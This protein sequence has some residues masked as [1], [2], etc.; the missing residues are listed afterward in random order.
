MVSMKDISQ[1]C[2]VSV[3]TVSKALNNH[4]DISEA[5]KKMIR[6]C[7]REMGY[8]PNSSARALKT[9]RTFNLGVLF[10][11][12]ARNGLTHSFF[13]KVLDSFKVTAEAS[14]Y[15]LTFINCDRTTQK[16]TFLEH[17]RYRGV[18]GV[19]V[20]AVDFESEEVVDLVRSDLPVVTI[21][22]S[23]DN[24]PS[25]ISD[26][27]KGI[28][29]LVSYIVG[30]GHTRIAYITGGD[31]SSVTRNRVS[32]F[33]RTLGE[34]G[35]TIPDIY[36]QQG[37]YR[38]PG[39]CK[40]KTEILLDLKVPPTCILYP[41]DFSMIG[42]LNALN[43]R[44]LTAG[45]D[46]SVAGYDGIDIALYLEPK[47]TTISQDCEAIGREAAEKLIGLIEHPKTTLME[48]C[49]IPGKLLPGDS[50]KVLSKRSGA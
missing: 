17:S 39:L 15:D 22:H 5:T 36:L 1:R 32:S 44:G 24:K 11:D 19:V 18:D 34:Y 37:D 23:F 9:N 35:I 12:R 6:N 14:G 47:F 29:D 28:H 38:N 50:V 4:S 42:G 30:C 3:A 7:A 16:M 41:D 40:E 8:F 45:K 43:E 33:Y 27:V 31:T 26:N 20:A 46:V 25:I 2:G 10:V 49:V 21:D 13:A 48:R